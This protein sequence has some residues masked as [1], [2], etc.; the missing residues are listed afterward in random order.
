MHQIVPNR[1]NA[2]TRGWMSHASKFKPR[3]SQL[4]GHEKVKML[5]CVGSN[6]GIRLDAAEGC[7]KRIDFT[8]GLLTLV[9]DIA[10]ASGCSCHTV[11]VSCVLGLPPACQNQLVLGTSLEHRAMVPDPERFELLC[12]YGTV[13]GWY[14]SLI[15]LPLWPLVACRL[16]LAAK[17]SQA[18]TTR[19]PVQLHRLR[20]IRPNTQGNPR[21]P[22][23]KPDEQV[24][25]VRAVGNGDEQPRYDCGCIRS[26][27]ETP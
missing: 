22:K 8:L 3:G 23:A 12:F 19:I 16:S 17:H 13:A 15:L 2:G 1:R 4:P 18:S 6:F 7:G 21:N 10:C 9:T 20:A 25:R 27:F 26:P 5:G 24:S 14:M 11:R